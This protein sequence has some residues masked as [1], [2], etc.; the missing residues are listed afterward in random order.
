MNDLIFYFDT[1][2]DVLTRLNEELRIAMIHYSDPL[3]VRY[4]ERT[5]FYTKIVNK[6]KAIN[7]DKIEQEEECTEEIYDP[8][9]DNCEAFI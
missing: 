2:I 1:K 7:W 6:L 5:D 8:A 3:R 9:K 4:Q